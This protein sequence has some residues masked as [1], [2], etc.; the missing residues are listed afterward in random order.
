MEPASS[1]AQLFK[2]FANSP[3]TLLFCILFGSLLAW[4]TPEFSKTLAVVGLVYVDLLKMIVLPFMVSLVI[5]SLQKLFRAGNTTVIIGRVVIVFSAFS[6]IAALAGAVGTLII[7]PGTDMSPSTKAALGRIVN[8]DVDNSNTQM[9]LYTVEAAPKPLSLLDVVAAFIPTNIFASLANGETLKVLVFALIF[10]VAVGKVPGKTAASLEQSLET[11]NQA[12]QGLTRWINL[13]VPF[14]LVCMTASQL[15]DTGFETMRAMIGFVGV[16]LGIST[17]LLLAAVAV[18]AHRAGCSYVRVLDSMREPFSLGVA[19]NNSATCMPAM[20]EAL[21]E[22]LKFSR[23]QSELLVPLSVTLLRSGA[24]V[25]FVCGTLFI[26]ALYGRQ[27]SGME[28][29]FAILVSV[30]SGFASTGM[31]GIATIAMIGSA[32]QYLGMPFEAAFLLL[33]AVDPICAMARTVVTVI[34]SCAAVA[35]VCTRPIQSENI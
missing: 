15:A 16:F 7:R 3:L 22:Q 4:L 1:L 10:G 24:I 6:F 20:V 23:S 29:G 35:T 28:V 17:L 27:L 14:V 11:I 19:T 30:L 21:A 18:L 32:C 33:V 34:G 5:L 9:S 31:A 2:R 12:C 26:A 13:P 25:Y 8:T